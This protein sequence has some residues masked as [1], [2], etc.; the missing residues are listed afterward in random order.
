M[1]LKLPSISQDILRC[2]LCDTPMP[3]LYCQ[4]CDINL[5]KTCAGDHLVDE[6]K[7]HRVVPIKQK[8]NP[9]NPLC[10]KHTT[11]HCD[12]YCK[13]CNNP[14]CALCVLSGEHDQHEKMDIFERKIEKLENELHQLEHSICPKYNDAALDIKIKKDDIRANSKKLRTMINEHGQ[15]WHNEIDNIIKSLLSKI[16]DNE[17]KQLDIF[18]SE[19]RKI[20]L[21][22]N[23]ILKNIQDLKNLISSRDAHLVPEY[24]TKLRDFS[25]LPPHLD[26]ALPNFMPRS[27]DKSL[28]GHLSNCFEGKALH[29]AMYFGIIPRPIR[30]LSK[31][32]GPPG[33]PT[34]VKK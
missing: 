10:P 26:M 20:H 24:I 4:L 7:E 6:T 30:N 21:K 25:D 23:E 28:F 17:S 19:E 8:W 22:T 32:L 1:D 9:R 13:Q 12:F 34:L 29:N 15:A 5:C 18:E 16:D 14:I 27:I 2:N 31:Y 33:F 11:K 3:P